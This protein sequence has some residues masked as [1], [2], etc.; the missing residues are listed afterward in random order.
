MTGTKAKN[1]LRQ[2]K[3]CTYMTGKEEKKCNWV[4][5]D[6]LTVQL[7]VQMFKARAVVLSCNMIG[8]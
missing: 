1:K 2:K 7:Y 6:N 4:P 8:E 5:T 3:F